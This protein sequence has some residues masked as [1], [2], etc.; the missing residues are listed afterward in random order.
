MRRK[1]KELIL[2][3]AAAVTHESA[4]HGGEYRLQECPPCAMARAE[5]KTLF[6]PSAVRLVESEDKEKTRTD[7]LRE[8]TEDTVCECVCESV[9]TYICQCEPV[10][11]CV[12]TAQTTRERILAISMT[13]ISKIGNNFFQNNQK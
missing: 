13:L 2:L 9:N 7:P 10:R 1:V 11:Q 6:P 12:T 8:V 4:R 5:H 3:R